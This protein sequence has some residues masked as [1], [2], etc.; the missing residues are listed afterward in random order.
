MGFL[1]GLYHRKNEHVFNCLFA[2]DQLERELGLP[3]K[4]KQ[5]WFQEEEDSVRRAGMLTLQAK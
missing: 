3:L 1:F 2:E 4:H 5:S